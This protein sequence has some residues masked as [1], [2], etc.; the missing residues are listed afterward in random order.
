L[1]WL[2]PG[3]RM[4]PSQTLQVFLGAVVAL[5]YAGAVLAIGLVC[6]TRFMDR[7][8]S[9][10]VRARITL[11]G[12]VWLGFIIGQ[13]ILGV[14][15]LVLSL[16]GILHAGLVGFVCALGWI[17]GF[18]VILRFKSDAAQ[19]FKLI[20]GS[21]S[22]FLHGQSWYLWVAV[23]VI[24][25]GLLGALIALLPTMNDDALWVYLTVAKVIGVSHTLAFQPF[26]TPHNAVYPL[27]V[28]MHWAA[29]FAISNETAVTVWDYLCALSFLCG[30]GLISWSLTS[31]RRVVLLAVLMMLSTP[32]FYNLM[33]SGKVDNAA[34]QYGVA[35]FLALLLYPVLRQRSIIL[36]GLYVG[37]AMA[38]RYTNVILLPALM[39][40]AVIVIRRFWKAS[41]EIRAKD[42]LKIPW[43]T[44]AL[45][46]GLSVAVSGVPML[47]KNWLLVGCPLAPQ[48]GCQGTFWVT[49][50]QGGPAPN[51]SGSDL[52]L[53]P[54]VW[55]FGAREDML[56]NISPVFLGFLPFLLAYY[57]LPIVR[58]SLLAGLAGLASVTTWLL[59][60]PF[61]LFT[62]FFLVPLGL[63]TVPLSASVVAVEE[64]LRHGR[65]A[66]WLI[67]SSIFLILFF[68]LFQSRT[69]VYAF[70]YLASIDTRAAKYEPVPH[71]GYDVAAWL[72]S[73]AQT[74][75]RVALGAWSGHP[76]FMSP[77][78]LLNSESTE[79]LE[80]LWTHCR[81]RSPAVWTTDFWHFYARQGFTYVIVAKDSVAEAISVWSND[82]GE[83]PPQV[84]FVGRNN[85]VLRL[86]QNGFGRHELSKKEQ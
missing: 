41:V 36:A 68:L 39:L 73:H 72:N 55:T 85:V 77:N 51:I 33:G 52:I 7:E 26:A 67:R 38:A 4:I 59:I 37:W 47:I 60:E 19:T 3:E 65:T 71:F 80:W 81:C 49:R 62:R 75:Q 32:G 31:S 64:D 11:L 58:H 8:E 13:G 63:L 1:F 21:F 18:L 84:A 44:Y 5:L 25:A 14:A 57:R 6:L 82:F 42:Q 10:A 29:L 27:Q 48:F 28:E 2:V 20:G 22:S 56:G 16:G 46:G 50:Y 76:Y 34:A 79:E 78:H 74:G 66:R 9:A 86:E 70:R 61:I 40:F 24:V 54:F 53:Y 35:A 30:I 23:G 83:E 45:V 12:F 69:A 17:L 15:W 43:V